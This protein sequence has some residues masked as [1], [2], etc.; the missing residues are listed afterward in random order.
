MHAAHR[1]MHGYTYLYALCDSLVT[2]QG[3][4]GLQGWFLYLVLCFPGG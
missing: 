1:A 4:P 3:R 2:M